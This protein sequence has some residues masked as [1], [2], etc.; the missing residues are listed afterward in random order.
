MLE[1]LAKTVYQG[2]SF[3]K[4]SLPNLTLLESLFLPQGLFINNKGA[5]PMIMSVPDY[6]SMLS[7]NIESGNIV[8]INEVDLKTDVQIIGKV[9]QVKSEYQLDFEGKDGL[10]TRYGVNLF[11]VILLNSEWKISSMCWDDKTDKSLLGL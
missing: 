9:G 6:I 5:E 1:E 3:E 4:G 10:F 11:Q 8:S 7:R 2:I